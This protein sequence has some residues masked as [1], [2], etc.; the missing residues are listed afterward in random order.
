MLYIVF[1]ALVLTGCRNLVMPKDDSACDLS[2]LTVYVY[3]DES[4]MAL[5]NSFDVLS[6]NLDAQTGEGTFFFPR[7][8]ALYNAT[9]LSRCRLEAVIPATASL[10]AYDEEGNPVP[11]GLGGIWDLANHSVGIDVVAANGDSKHYE[12]LFRMRR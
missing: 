5:Y 10:K 1:A 12:I 8:P 2:A 11:G 6:G 3:Y 7:D 9:T 4:N